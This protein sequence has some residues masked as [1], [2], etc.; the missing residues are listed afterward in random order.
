MMRCINRGDRLR[1]TLAIDDDIL[2][3]AR[4][5]AERENK[6][7]GEVVSELARQGSPPPAS[8]TTRASPC[9]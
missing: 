4:H 7:I 6:S 9:A 5:L 3:A 2:A 1:T 8:S